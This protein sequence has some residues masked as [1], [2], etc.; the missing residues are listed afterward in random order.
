[1]AIKGVCISAQCLL[2]PHTYPAYVVHAYIWIS[3]L[4]VHVS[5]WISPKA[6]PEERTSRPVVHWGADPRKQEWGFVKSETR[7]WE[8]LTKGV[9]WRVPLW[10][11]GLGSPGGPSGRSMRSVKSA[12]EPFLL[13][14]P[15]WNIYSWTPTAIGWGSSG[16]VNSPIL[17]GCLVQSV[18]LI[19]PKGRIP[20]ICYQCL[21]SDAGGGPG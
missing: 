11:T 9:L 18:A 10:A 16:T 21:R 20:E 13:Q 8:K 17:E 14:V 6:E 4:A 2:H 15:S 7:K 3:K 12:S 19:S 5:C 1:M